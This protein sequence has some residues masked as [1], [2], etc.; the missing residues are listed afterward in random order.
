MGMM[1]A[2]AL[3]PTVAAAQVTPS[4][5]TAAERYSASHRGIA[6]LVLQDGK[7]VCEVYTGSNASTANELWSGT[8]SFVGIM[9]AAAVQ[10]GLL[11]LDE[12]AAD[13]LVEWKGDPRKSTITLR[14]LLSMSAGQGGVIGRP[15]SYADAVRA[16]LAS[17]PGTRFEY[18]PTP[19]QLFGEIMRRKL[20]AKGLDGNPLNYLKRRILDPIGLTIGSWRDGPDGNPL[21]PQGASLTSRNWAKLGEFVRNGGRLQGK[22]LVDPAA[23][24]ALFQPSALNPAYGLTWWLPHSPKMADPVTAGS[25][26]GAHAA[27]LPVDIVTAAGAGDQRMYVIPSLRLTIVRQARLDIAALT[28]GEKSGWSDFAFLQ[29]IGVRR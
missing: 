7:I 28:R 24:D 5:C 2:F 3:L 25:D 13:T 26:L 14:Q 19:M 20:I 10:D 9:A 8:K 21:L 6:V 29:T 27:D 18:G 1:V 22:P 12:L 4:Q 16:P 11:T 17:T 23:F 15:P